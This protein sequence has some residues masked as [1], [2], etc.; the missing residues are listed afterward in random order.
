MIANHKPSNICSLCWRQ[1]KKKRGALTRRS[2][3]LMFEL[4][5]RVCPFSRQIHDD[6]GSK[7]ITYRFFKQVEGFLGDLSYKEQEDHF[8]EPV[9]WNF[10]ALDRQWDTSAYSLFTCM[11]SIFLPF[12]LISSNVVF[13]RHNNHTIYSK[14][15]VSLIHY[16]AFVFLLYFVSLLSCSDPVL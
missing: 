13:Y 16:L 11:F 7:V 15:F 14:I 6:F 5:L 3:L 10:F 2:T 8:S 1:R 9:G 12:C 4:M